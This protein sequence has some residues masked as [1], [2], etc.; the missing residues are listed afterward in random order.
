MQPEQKLNGTPQ[1]SADQSG[2]VICAQCGAPMPEGMRFCRSCGQRLGEGSAEYTETVRLP[3]ATG[4]AGDR[5]TTR[6]VPGYRA[7]IARQ[8]GSG[9]LYRQRRRFSGMTW[10]FIAI[11]IFFGVGGLLST[12]IKNV[13]PNL[14]T[15]IRGSAPSNRSYFGVD[16]FENA[17]GGATF[18]AVEP[19]GAPADKAGLVGG[20][21]ITSFDGHEVKGEDQMMDLLR[22]TPVGKTVEVVY[23]RDGETKKTQMTTISNDAFN[24]LASAF[25]D[26]PE[27]RGLFGYE[28]SDSKRVKIEG[29]NMY[30]V[31][32]DNV[33][34]NAPADIAGIKEGDIVIEFDGVPI[35]TSDELLSR[36]RRAIPKDVVNVVVMRDG[37]RVE[38]PVKMGKAN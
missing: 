25:E 21:I 28:Q 22:Q 12:F 20:D 1:H 35:R 5:A 17:D 27:G 24:D 2:S 29:T 31:R 13:R 11:A 34:D 38:I 33:S 36:V 16:G 9:F 8:T 18:D 30:G 7:P 26:R 6:F 3:N 15:S 19:P 14:P 4:P 23:V 10:V 32:L 37:Q